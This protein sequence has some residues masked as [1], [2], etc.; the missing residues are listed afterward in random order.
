MINFEN[1]I[2]GVLNEYDFFVIPGL[3]AF[4]AVYTPP[5]INQN[6]Q[7]IEPI[8][9]FRFNSLLIEDDADKFVSYITR[10]E[11]LT[12]EEANLQLK[13]FV[14]NFKK[15]LNANGV[16]S[17]YGLGEFTIVDNQ[18]HL[19]TNVVVPSN[20]FGNSISV[21]NHSQEPIKDEESIVRAN[22]ETANL[23][24]EEAIPPIKNK[25]KIYY[26]L[27]LLPVL[28]LIWALYY[29]LNKNNDDKT[30]VNEPTQSIMDTVTQVDLDS[31]VIDTFNQKE[32]ISDLKVKNSI[33]LKPNK[34]DLKEKKSVPKDTLI[35]K[36]TTPIKS[37]KD[38]KTVRD[39]F[40]IWAGLFRQKSN[41]TKTINLLKDNGLNPK[42]EIIGKNSRVYV[43]A[44]TESE[45]Q[46]LVKK[47]EQLTGEKA[48]YFEN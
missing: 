38:L 44:E 34:D 41:A 9:S 25:S 43:S 5:E 2:T 12:K 7:L 30:L 36:N 18:I 40:H 48:V 35:V 1:Y 31:M 19:P 46:S 26:L 8:K 47:I 42:V 24:K 45:A 14:F 3:G 15:H 6:G 22:L 33:A 32:P 20:D 23:E 16:A 21:I 11:K 17:I 27:Y 39:N 37:T 28:F 29:S 13:E 10:F 4:I